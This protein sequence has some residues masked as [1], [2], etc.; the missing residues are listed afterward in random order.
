[1]SAELAAIDRI[2]SAGGDADDVLRQVVAALHERFSWVGIAFVE[3]ERLVLGPSTGE[4]PP[5]TT[6]VPITYDGRRVAELR[7]V[8]GG[9]RAFLEGVAERIAPY[10]LVGWDTGGEAWSP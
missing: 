4:P 9:E 8:D 10:C 2:V 7:V 3:D 6:D 5:E 1:V